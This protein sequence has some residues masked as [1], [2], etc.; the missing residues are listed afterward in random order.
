MQKQCSDLGNPKPKSTAAD[1]HMFSNLL[2]S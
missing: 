1:Y 2:I